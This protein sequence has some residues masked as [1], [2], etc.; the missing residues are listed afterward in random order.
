MEKRV[1]PSID[2]CGTPLVT[3]SGRERKRSDVALCTLTARAFDH[4]RPQPHSIGWGRDGGD[5]QF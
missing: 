5:L 3:G 4:P 2:P 1:R